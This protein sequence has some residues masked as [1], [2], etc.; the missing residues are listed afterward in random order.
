MNGKLS[1]FRWLLIVV[2]LFGTFG[3]VSFVSS[4]SS[5]PALTVNVAA[6]NHAISPY[7]Y[8]MNFASEAIAVDLRL[9][10]RRWGGDSTTRY[11][12]QLDVKGL[13]RASRF[14]VQRLPFS[15]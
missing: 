13:A 6:D 3:N 2:I 5:G 9:P 1:L 14:T 11:N 7:I 12:W 10:V 4:A 15:P 8:G